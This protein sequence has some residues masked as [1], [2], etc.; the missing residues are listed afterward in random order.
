M[1]VRYQDPIPVAD[2]FRTDATDAAAAMTLTKSSSWRYED[3][4]RVMI[5]EEGRTQ[6]DFPPEALTAVTFGAHLQSDRKGQP[7]D[8]LAQRDQP[9]RVHRMEINPANYRLDGTTEVRTTCSKP[10]K[11]CQERPS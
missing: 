3:E 2:Y 9:I 6:V 11:T 1:P 7:L 10:R 5:A 8:L 4:W